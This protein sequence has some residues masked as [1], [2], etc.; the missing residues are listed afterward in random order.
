MSNPFTYVW[1]GV[2]LAMRVINESVH[3]PTGYVLAWVAIGLA[4][5]FY[6]A[7]KEE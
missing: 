3:V 6:L 7:N 1:W 4:Y 5:A 2:F